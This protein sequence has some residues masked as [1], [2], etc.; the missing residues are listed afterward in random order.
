MPPARRGGFH[1]ETRAARAPGRGARSAGAVCPPSAPRAAR[2]ASGAAERPAGGP[3]DDGARGRGRRDRGVRGLG[4]GTARRA[5]LAAAV[6]VV[7]D[8]GTEW[9]GTS[10]TLSP[11][12][13]RI[14]LQAAV[15][16]G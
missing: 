2:R 6:H 1:R 10:V 3:R 11:F 13:V 15:R 9:F 4:G 16:P 12:S 8:D 14:R 5:A 7:E